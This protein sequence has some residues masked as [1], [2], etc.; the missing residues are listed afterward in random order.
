MRDES[1]L[2][3]HVGVGEREVDVAPSLAPTSEEARNERAMAV[4]RLV[5]ALAT[6][7][8][9]VAQPFGW[10]PLGIDAEALYAVLSG[11]GAIAASLWAW[12]KNNNVTRAAQAGQRVTDAIKEDGA[13]G[14]T[15]TVY[16]E[17]E[18]VVTWR[19]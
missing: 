10:E 1:D 12:W 2:A 6:V 3:G 18:G 16:G 15:L 17:R 4:V 5:V 11:A 13:I 9:I 8:N 7:V 14:A 19:S